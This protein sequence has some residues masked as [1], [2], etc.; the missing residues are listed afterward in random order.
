MVRRLVPLTVL[1]TALAL[2]GIAAA[3]GPDR[4]LV[5]GRGTCRVIAGARE[6]APLLETWWSG[7]FTQAGVP[8]PAPY[9]RITLEPTSGESGRW[10][11]VWVPSKRLLRVTQIAVPP[12]ETQS[13][14]PYWR[15]VPPAAR[16]A[17]ASATRGL[18]PHPPV[19]G[20]GVGSGSSGSK[21]GWTW[22]SLHRP[23][24]LPRLEP[25]SACP[26][27]PQRRVVL[28]RGDTLSLPGPGPAYPN[29]WPGT[30][31]RFFWPPLPTQEYAGSGWSGNKVMWLVSARYKGPV[32]VRG[33]QLDGPHLVRFELGSPPRA[34]LR[35][36]PGSTGGTNGVRRFP[37]STRVQ[38]P[39]C[40]A[41][42]VDGP[43]F[44]RVVVFQA[45]VIPPP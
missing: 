15:P 2:T 8:R 30:E 34:E 27:S 13:V 39:G 6:I 9:F 16:A 12:Y 28:G 32:L 3:K 25:G 11:L 42:Q 37:S 7:P 35:L 40:Y 36:K 29:L 38:A 33:R 18:E 17:F 5:C 26:V 23:L 24:A 21:P 45:R 41:Y 10:L 44:S 4:A 20:W 19:T 31:L 43:S 22:A 14:G 1:G